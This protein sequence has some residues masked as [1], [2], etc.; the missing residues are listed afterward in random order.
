MVLIE[1][2]ACG[3]IPIATDH[4]G[5]KEIINDNIDGFLTN[6]NNFTK[7]ID[8]IINSELNFDKIR[9]NAISNAKKYSTKEISMKWESIFE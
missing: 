3:V 1:A 2:M 9:K 6:E 5:P 7:K 8:F 4:K